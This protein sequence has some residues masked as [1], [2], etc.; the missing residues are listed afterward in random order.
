MRELAMYLQQPPD[1]RVHNIQNFMNRLR[2]TPQVYFLISPCFIPKPGFVNLGRCN[3]YRLDN[4]FETGDLNLSQNWFRL[5][6]G[7]LLRNKSF[8]DSEIVR[9][10]LPWVKAQIGTLHLRVSHDMCTCVSSSSSCANSLTSVLTNYFSLFRQEY[11]RID[12]A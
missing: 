11:V 4:Y 10:M 12:E 6:V 5:K 8:L 1:R 2:T 3:F 7:L 9:K